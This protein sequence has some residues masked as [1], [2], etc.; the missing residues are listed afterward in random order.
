MISVIF[1]G[2]CGFIKM[3]SSCRSLCQRY[4]LVMAVSFIGARK[5]IICW[6]NAKAVSFFSASGWYSFGPQSK[7]NCFGGFRDWVALVSRAPS[8]CR[9]CAAEV[10]MNPSVV[11]R[12]FYAVAAQGH[13]EPNI[14]GPLAISKFDRPASIQ[15]RPV[16]GPIT[17]SE[18]STI[19]PSLIKWPLSD[20][21]TAPGCKSFA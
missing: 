20:G 14:H 17:N 5:L 15:S 9:Y 6:Y 2:L 3:F 12:R 1:P 18:S 4:G 19:L 11:T 7:A 10:P 16:A 8:A 21:G 13:H